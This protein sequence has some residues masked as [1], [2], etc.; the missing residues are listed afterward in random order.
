MTKSRYDVR[1]VS[2]SLAVSESQVQ[3]LCAS[4]KLKGFK[5]AGRWYVR[6]EDLMQYKKEQGIYRCVLVSR[7]DVDPNAEYL[8]VGQL[9]ALFHDLRTH[10]VANWYNTKI[11]P[12][13]R[14]PLSDGTYEYNVADVRARLEARRL[15]QS[16]G[17]DNVTVARVDP[18]PKQDDL[19]LDATLGDEFTGI[20]TSP[21]KMRGTATYVSLEDFASVFGVSKFAI[22]KHTRSGG[23]DKP[24][25]RS[26]TG[27]SP[28]TEGLFLVNKSDALEW[29]AWYREKHPDVAPPKPQPAVKPTS[30]EDGMDFKGMSREEVIPHLVKMVMDEREK[31]SRLEAENLRLQGDVDRLTSELDEAT[32]PAT[33][34]T[35]EEEALNSLFDSPAVS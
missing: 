18:A 21:V 17:Q 3:K 2:K 23:G 13:R 16:V 1:E 9:R 7:D 30:K 33:L 25:V 6:H 14:R 29:L 34:T 24:F 19:L 22:H 32:K 15:K 4:E 35:T 5:L 12:I 27:D 20:T 11:N 10:D 26:F 28:P 8:S 31:V